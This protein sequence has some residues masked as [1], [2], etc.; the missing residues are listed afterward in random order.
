MA[1]LLYHGSDQYFEKE[2]LSKTRGFLDFGKG[3][4]LTTYLE[5]AQEWALRKS[6]MSDISTRSYIYEYQFDE[7][8]RVN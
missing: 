7:N 4:Y 6:R 3:F 2:D 8:V 5:Q 1:I